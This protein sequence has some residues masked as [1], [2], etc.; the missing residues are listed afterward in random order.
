M[1]PGSNTESYPAFAHIGL[2]ENPG[3]NLNQVTCP[4]RDSNPGHLVSRPYALTVTPQYEL[5]TEVPKD[6]ILQ[7][8]DKN[9]SNLEEVVFSDEATFHLCSKVNRHNY[10]IWGSEKPRAIMEHQ[11]DTENVNVWIGLMHNAIIGLF[12]FLEKTVTGHSYLDMLENFVVLQ[13]P[14]GSTFQQNC[15]PPHYYHDVNS[16]LHRN[17]PRHWIGRGGPKA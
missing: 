6:K 9:P 10:S 16:F 8:I 2:R 7:L 17:F 4:D 14:L 15:A 11:R 3:K 12:F 1:N 5:S 13:I